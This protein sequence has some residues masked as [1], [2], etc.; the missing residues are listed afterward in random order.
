M[1][2]PLFLPAEVVTSLAGGFNP[3]DEI[4][5]ILDL[6]EVARQEFEGDKLQI[7]LLMLGGLEPK[8]V[9]EKTQYSPATVSRVKSVLRGAYYA[10]TA[11]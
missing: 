3:H 7:A 9:C 6:E 2:D 8:E 5:T 10:E 11:T 4:I 1:R